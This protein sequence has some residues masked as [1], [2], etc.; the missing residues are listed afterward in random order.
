MALGSRPTRRRGPRWLIFA[1]IASVVVLAVN[2]AMSARSLAPARDLAQQSYLDQ[3]LPVIQQSTQEGKDIATVR[4]QA[5]KLGAATMAT[6]LQDVTTS[7]KQTLAQVQR[8]T[9]PK[10][11]Q[12]AHDLLMATL[13]IRAEGADAF[14][15][16]MSVAIS[17]QGSATPVQQI[18]DVGRD[19]DAGDRAYAL[20]LKAM[21]DVNVSIP[22]SQ[23]A[24]DGSSYTDAEVR[25]FLATLRSASSLAPVHDVSVVMVSTDPSAVGMNGTTAV[26]PISKILNMQI[27]VADVG[28]QPEKNLMVTATIAP[29][30][31]GSSEMV[32]DF[33]DFGPGQRRTVKLGGLRPQ[34]GVPTTLTVK[35]DTAPGETNVADNSKVITFVMQ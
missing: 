22:P 33:V 18:V 23:W 10:A 1:V 27:V 16:A 35:I 29:S 2:A 21:P 11:L 7:A 8:L 25:V 34:A 26:W 13:A 12:T 9:P 3:V 32:R 24:S 19:F 15:V 28:N 20:F 6:R 4:T 30:T 14:R 5:L 31:N 17:G